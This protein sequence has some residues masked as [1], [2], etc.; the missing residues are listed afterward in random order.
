MSDP[1]RNSGNLPAELTSFVGRRTELSE[2]K[3]LLTG[4]RLVTLTGM[5]G[6]GKT[7]LALRTGAGLRRAFSDGVW[8]VRLAELTDPALLPS[9]IAAELGLRDGIPAL[10]Q[11]V[12]DKRLL[13]I[14]DNCEHLVDAC[15]VLVDKLLSSTPGVRILV[16]SRQILRADGE[17]V[18]VV[19]PLP[20][21]AGPHEPRHGEAV[22]LFADRA[23]GVLPGFAID[24]GNRELVTH[25]CRRLDG[26]PLAIE[27]A[28]VR[29][30]VLSLEQILHRLDDRFRLLTTGNRTAPARQQ[31][32]EAA[33][34]WSF[35]LCTPQEKAVW[36][37]TSVL[38]GGFDLEAAEAVCGGEALDLVA[39]LVDKSILI[40]RDGTYDRSAW[41]RMLETVRE[42][43]GLKL[44]ESGQAGTV[45]ARHV[46][47][48]AGL[49][50]RYEKESFGPQQLEWIERLRR[51]R[52][53]VRVALEHCLT[54]AGNVDQAREI[55]ADLRGFWY[56][57]GFAAEGRR[58]LDAVL[59]LDGEPTRGRARALEACAY[60]ALQSGEHVVAHEMLMELR[61]L[62]ERFEDEL[63]RAG[64][65]QCSGLAR[66]FEGDLVGGR[67]RLERA[68]E[69]YRRLGQQRQVFATLILLSAVTFFLEDP[70]GARLAGEA[71]EMCETRQASWSKMYALWAVAIHEW[72]RGA[73]GRA[74]SLLREVV[75][76]RLD[77]RT[78][79]ACAVGGLAWCAGALG[80]HERA[81]GLLGA[82]QS[83]WVLSGGTGAGPYRALDEQCAERARQVIGAEA[84]AAAFDATARAGLDEV[85]S[86]ALA[87]K[88]SKPAR[89]VRRHAGPPGGLTPREREIAELIAEGLSNRE[90]AARLVIA[91]RTAETHVEN[92]LAKLGFTSRAQIAAWL[93]E[94]RAPQGQPRST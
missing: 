69:G 86:Y 65:A 39:A 21:P 11:Y 24:A 62:A 25:I 55:A 88:A 57:S 32:L 61:A 53:N 79:L 14:L 56:A 38:A 78:Q 23:A 40:R 63:L 31:T 51:E 26:V 8:F 3:R 7:R 90:I 89:P 42:Y 47:Y 72:R 68:L 13:L 15:A 17:Q 19:P 64:Y 49:A 59:A 93:A 94:H 83:A 77:D 36:A 80:Q 73:H 20:L 66:F 29:L 16:T 50:R 5:G 43:G 4:S 33:I 45:H 30:R 74:A 46:G 84:F 28:A 10:A 35:E 76:M 27:L 44:G 6:V 58:W 92:I 81:A 52:V 2:A 1:P 87:E 67:A 70:A 22:T 85:I 82:A 9:A 37:A 12:E 91:Q 60:M 41:Y 18:L 48:V 75:V 54:P 71:L 34:A